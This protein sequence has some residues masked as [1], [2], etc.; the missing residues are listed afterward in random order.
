[1]RHT[2]ALPRLPPKPTQPNPTPLLLPCGV[3]VSFS[4][5][6]RWQ[7]APRSLPGVPRDRI[8]CLDIDSDM[9]TDVLCICC[10]WGA[11]P[12]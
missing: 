5:D 3:H 8:D 7:K 2:P 6:K 10:T 11:D 9:E 12:E 1:M 4:P